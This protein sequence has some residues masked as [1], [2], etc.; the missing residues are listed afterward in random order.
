MFAEHGLD[1]YAEGQL[2]MA[3][4]GTEEAVALARV[5]G[6]RRAE[7]AAVVNV[8]VYCLW[9]GDFGRALDALNAA[10]DAFDEVPDVF[11]RHELPLCFAARGVLWA[12]RG[13]SR[14]AERGFKRGL[15]AADQVHASRCQAI[16]RALRAE[17]TAAVDA[18][19]A[20]RDSAAALREC[21]RRGD[22]SWQPWANQ[23]PV[24]QPPKPAS[25]TRRRSCGTSSAMFRHRSKAHV[26]RFCSARSCR[27]RDETAR[28]CRW[29]SMYGLVVLV[30]A[31]IAQ[32]LR[33]RRRF[34]LAGS[35]AA[36]DGGAWGGPGS[37]AAADG[38]VVVCD[39]LAAG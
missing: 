20:R 24:C 13:D 2:A 39:G 35:G 4:A 23:A 16:V 8:G 25:T 21:K 33:R 6:A 10:E 15:D 27:A 19:R 28:R 12:L 9:T 11:E 5:R 1:A 14:A 32:R 36:D 37:G 17:F 26:P 18:Q 7:V 30:G 34:L 22:V 3:L 29:R 38:D 31:L